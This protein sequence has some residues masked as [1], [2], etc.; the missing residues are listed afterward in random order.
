MSNDAPI[1]LTIKSDELTQAMKKQARDCVVSESRSYVRSHV[2][3]AM[4]KALAEI[5]DRLFKSAMDHWET[6]RMLADFQKAMYKSLVDHYN[7]KASGMQDFMKDSIAAFCEEQVN[8]IQFDVVISKLIAQRLGS[9]V[10]GIEEAHTKLQAQAEEIDKKLAEL[11]RKMVD[12]DARIKSA[13][14]EDE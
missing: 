13:V 8:R 1:Q 4:N 7:T 2:D 14:L 6:K 12:F 9:V 5:S 3:T 11:D 10:L